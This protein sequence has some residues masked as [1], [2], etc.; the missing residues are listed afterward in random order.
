MNKLNDSLISVGYSFIEVNNTLEFD[1]ELETLFDERTMKMIKKLFESL[2][3]I[4][5]RKTHKYGDSA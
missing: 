4:N 1:K 2:K 5:Y 3:I